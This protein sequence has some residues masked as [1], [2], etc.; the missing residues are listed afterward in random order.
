MPQFKR[1]LLERLM[2]YHHYLRDQRPAGAPD[3]VSS[4]QIA[5]FVDHDDTQVRKDL[6]AIGVRGLPR[7]GFSVHQ[8]VKATSNVL[9]FS[10]P[11][12]AAIIGAGQLGGALAAYPGF[13]E[14]GLVTAAVLDVAP[15]KIGSQVGNLTVEPMDRLEEIIR[16]RHVRLA[17]LTVPADVAQDIADRLVRADIVAIWNFAPTGLAVPEGVLV[18]NEHIS[19]G[20]AELAYH[21]KE[22][23][24]TPRKL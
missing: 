16:T 5:E 15:E 3:T 6:A 1:T 18:R 4:A 8:V 19:I 12:N 11:Y 7:V 24:R 23:R 22:A 20:L 21:L 9:G 13:A 17:I 10:E 14:Y 2:Q